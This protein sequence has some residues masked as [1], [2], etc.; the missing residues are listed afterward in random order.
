VFISVKGQR[1][2][3]SLKVWARN[4]P[5]L[6]QNQRAGTG[7]GLSAPMIIKAHGGEVETKEGEGAG[8]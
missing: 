5:A 1:C 6:Q 3:Y 4:L 2:W 7:L 8:L